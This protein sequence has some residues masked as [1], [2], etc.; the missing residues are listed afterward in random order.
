MNTKEKLYQF[1][2]LITRIQVAIMLYFA[3][4][5]I[6]S[7]C[8]L[9][10]PLLKY[11]PAVDSN[12]AGIF[13]QVDATILTLTIALVTLISGS[14]TDSFMGISYSDYFLNLRPKRYKQIVIIFLSFIYFSFAVVFFLLGV[15]YLVCGFLF[16]EILLVLFSVF[17]LYSIFQGEYSIQKEISAYSLKLQLCKADNDE[18]KIVS[19]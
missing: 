8:E 17:S 12:T 19:K 5:Q 9:Q 16:C 14:I 10:L 4:L 2:K 15:Y 1:E 11:L 13:L 18:L 6:L 7:C 3:V